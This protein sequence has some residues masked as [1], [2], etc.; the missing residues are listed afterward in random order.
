MTTTGPGSPGAPVEAPREVEESSTEDALEPLFHLVLLDDDYH[1]YDYV[2]EMLGKLF[3]YGREKAFVLARMVDTHGRVIVETAGPRE[4]PA[5]PGQDS[6]LRTRSPHSRL[7]G[8]DVGSRRG[9]GVDAGRAAAR[10]RGRGASACRGFAES[11]ARVP[12]GARRRPGAR[13]PASIHVLARRPRRA[14]ELR[15]GVA[16]RRADR[17]RAAHPWPRARRPRAG[18][19]SALAG[20]RVRV[21]RCERGGSRADSGI[22]AAHTRGGGVPRGRRRAAGRLHDA[23]ARVAGLRGADA[24]RRGPRD[25]RRHGPAAGDGRRGPGVPDLHL[26]HAGAPEGRVARAAGAL[27]PRADVGRVGGL[28]TWATPRCTPAR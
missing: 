8:L 10:R 28:R 18:A 2:I 16:A 26:G 21:L 6:R 12:R 20:V 13:G 19:A 14:L 17:S 25:A 1:T 22:A 4:G 15:R 5:R 7:E 11:R 27:R 24:R 3:G 9:S 23:R